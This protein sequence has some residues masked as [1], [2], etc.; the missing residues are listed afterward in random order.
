PLALAWD[1]L[2]D[3]LSQLAANRV[4]DTLERRHVGEGVLGRLQAFGPEEAARL[5]AGAQWRGMMPALA[6]PLLWVQGPVL[7]LCAVALALLGWLGRRE[8]A[9]LGLAL[10]IG[11]GLL[12]NAFAT[13]ALSGPHDRYGAR[14]AWLVLAGAFVLGVRRMAAG[15]SAIHSPAA[16]CGRMTSHEIRPQGSCEAPLGQRPAVVPDAQAGPALTHPNHN[17]HET[18]M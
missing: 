16:H 18:V 13:G 17:K 7:V 10:G 2:R 14:V 5:Q 15:G 1:A 9:V 3:T 6:A 11:V 4:G 12:A 8:R